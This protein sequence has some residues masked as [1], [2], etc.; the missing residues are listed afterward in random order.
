MSPPTAYKMKVLATI[1]LVLVLSIHPHNATRVLDEEEERWLD[2]SLGSLQSLQKGPVAPSG[3]SG[4]TY[5]PGSNGPA[6]PLNGK[7]VAGGVFAP[8][9]AYY[10]HHVGSFGVASAHK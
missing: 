3:P 1:V 9:E 2:G 5:I 8:D 7:K 10:Q 4:C 6:C